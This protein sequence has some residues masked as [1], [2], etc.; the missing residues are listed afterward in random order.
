MV[1]TERP[2]GPRPNP[3]DDAGT[4]WKPQEGKDDVWRPAVPLAGYVLEE[5]LVHRIWLLLDRI[6]APVRRTV[7]EAF[8]YHLWGF[9]PALIRKV[10]DNFNRWKKGAIVY[11]KV[12]DESGS[13][14]YGKRPLTKRERA[15]LLRLLAKKIPGQV[16]GSAGEMY[17]RSHLKKCPRFESV[18]PLAD[19]GFKTAP[20]GTRRPD[21]FVTD[22]ATGQLYC[23]SAKNS[24]EMLEARD[25]RIGDAKKIA[26]KI[27]AK[28]REARPSAK[29]V[30]PW[31]ICSFAT[32]EAREACAREHVRLTTIEKRIA[33]RSFIREGKRVHAE[34]L[35]RKLLPAIGPQPWAFVTQAVRKET[36]ATGT[37]N[38]IDVAVI[39]EYDD[40]FL[41]RLSAP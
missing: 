26:A 32:P 11:D 4:A 1:S 3:Y 24:H 35:I 41:K 37:V 9:P 5:A 8:A 33:P 29:E 2:R 17:V 34:P 19:V 39:R 14:T 21:M 10:L 40:D 6:D 18:T 15:A 12:G 38:M 13:T 28:L 36:T 16:L 7:I 20:A 23:V 30:L 27:T 25:R 22:K 31:L